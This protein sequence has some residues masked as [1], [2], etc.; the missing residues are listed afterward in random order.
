MITNFEQYVT[1]VCINCGR[2]ITRSISPFVFSG[3]KSFT[4]LCPLCM[5]PCFD[6]TDHGK[7]Y[8]LNSSCSVCGDVHSREF[9]KSDFWNKE[10]ITAECDHTGINFIFFGAQDKVK[11]AYLDAQSDIH[12]LQLEEEEYFEDYTPADGDDMKG[13]LIASICELLHQLSDSNALLCRC[14]GLNISYNVV[15]DLICIRCKSCGSTQVLEPTNDL[16]DELYQTESFIFN[17]K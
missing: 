2:V 6:I 9:I 11:K 12:Q 7:R 17:K 4:V 16:L 1:Y 14:G 15:D 8:L 10:L 13:T 3:R 5:S